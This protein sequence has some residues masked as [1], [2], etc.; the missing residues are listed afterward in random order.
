MCLLQSLFSLMHFVKR[1][2][3]VVIV[4]MLLSCVLLL[5]QS[6]FINL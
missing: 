1:C 4:A 2:S 6:A 5:S 3:E